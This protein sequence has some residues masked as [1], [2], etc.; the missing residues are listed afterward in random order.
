MI[1]YFLKRLLLMIPTFFAI[2]LIAYLMTSN[3]TGTIV[4]AMS[5]YGEGDALDSFYEKIDAPDNRV[6]KFVRYCYD[7]VVHGEMG[8]TSSATF[9]KD[10]VAFRLK[11]T[12]GVAVLGFLVS[13]L[14]GIPLGVLAAV[15]HNRWPDHTVS[16]FSTFLASIPSYC[17]VLVLVFIFSLWLGI[18]PVSGIDTWKGYVMPVIVLGVGG[19]SLASRMT[20]SAVLEILSKPYLTVLRAKGLPEWK[21]LYKHVLKN[22][23]VPLLSVAGNIA[24]A[25]LCSTLI[26]EN[27]FSVPGIGAY[28]VNAVKGRDQQ[29]LLGSVVVLALIIMGIGFVTDMLGVLCSPKFR[30][31]IGKN[32]RKLSKG[33]DE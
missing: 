3:L 22:A 20:R 10:E 29:R 26:V 14:I 25:A 32:G 15:N 24:V 28:L 23:V 12:A 2:L 18:L 6:T 27:F 9:I 17:V 31:Q 4:D 21:I 30:K 13:I 11:Y 8:K 1:R 5:A 19:M 7:L 16:T 33:A